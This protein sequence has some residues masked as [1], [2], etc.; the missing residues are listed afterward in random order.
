MVYTMTSEMTESKGETKAK[1][2]HV[3]NLICYVTTARHSM[4]TNEIIRICITF[5][6][7]TDILRSKEYLCQLVEE[8][9]IHWC[10]EDRLVNEMKDIMDIITRCDD[11]DKTLPKFVADSY[12][13]LPPT[14]GFEV[15][16]N[17]IVQL[18]D[19][20][21]HLRKEL[22]QLKENRQ[23]ERICNQEIAFIKEDL[24][25][26]KGEVRK[27]NHKILCDDIRRDSILLKIQ[28][29]L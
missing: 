23:E 6:K 15:V 9:N 20:L 27:L 18:I 29:K 7:E 1:S 13:G 5:Y 28:Q 14:S 2:L 24:L 16:A 21:T 19:E 12:D 10:N 17:Y 4:K 3:D 22:A 8:R 25:E 11:K 26:I